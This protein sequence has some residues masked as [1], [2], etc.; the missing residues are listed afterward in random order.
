MAVGIAV[1]GLRGIGDGADPVLPQVYHMDKGAVNS[2]GGCRI[3]ASAVGMKARCPEEAVTFPADVD[4]W[5]M[6]MPG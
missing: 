2:P 4:G 5:L 1:R 3:H 6:E